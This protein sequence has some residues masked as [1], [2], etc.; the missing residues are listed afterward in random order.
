MN[1]NYKTRF[2][3][4]FFSY[5]VLT[6]CG[7]SDYINSKKIAGAPVYKK[8]AKTSRCEFNELR[9]KRAVNY[10]NA[11]RA[12][13]QVCGGKAYPASGPI[14]WNKQLQDA[15]NTHSDDMASND[16]FSHEGTTHAT[17]GKR[18]SHSGYAWKA[19]AENIAAGSDTPEQAIDQ[20][21]TSSGHCHNIMNS[22]YTEIGMACVINPLSEYRTYWT[23]V[24]ASPG[25]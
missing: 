17:V 23:L 13:S 15:A 25:S 4:V 10:I 20:W 14:T 2:I 6:S 5:F 12:K 1:R 8:P 22:A 16:F 24:L 21:M 11:Y 9:I 19:V 18:A 7:V 3:L